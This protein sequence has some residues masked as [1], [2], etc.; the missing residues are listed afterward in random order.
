MVSARIISFATAATLSLSAVAMAVPPNVDIT[1]TSSAGNSFFQPVGVPANPAGVYNYS[2]TDGSTG[3]YVVGWDLNATNENSPI[4]LSGNL[5]FQND[6]AFTQ[7]FDVWVTMNT[8]AIPN[9]PQLMGGSVAAGLTAGMDGGDGYFN[10]L[11]GSPLWSAYVGANNV[12]NLINLQAPVTTVPFGSQQV[13]SG[14]FG[15]PIPNEPGPSLENSISIRLRFEL[16]AFDQA[17]F[18][19]VFVIVPAPAGLAL[20][21]LVGF[22]RRRRQA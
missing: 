17:T 12:W 15:Q 6:T 8:T 2:G 9:T 1:V 14:N 10:S 19:S 18:T 4:F 13:G 11:G 7:T 5:N 20:L 21:G 22:T 16:G 3:N